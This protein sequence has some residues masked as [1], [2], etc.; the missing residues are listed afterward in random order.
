[1]TVAANR[2]LLR[3]LSVVSLCAAAILVGVHSAAAIRDGQDSG[4]V[5]ITADGC[6]H[7]PKG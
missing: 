7:C 3:R 6:A 4:T 2:V 1:M 5:R